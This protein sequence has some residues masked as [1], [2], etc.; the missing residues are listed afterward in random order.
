[1][2]A[3]LRA[4]F[5]FLTIL[6][7]PYPEDRQP[8]ASFAYFPLVGLLIGGL[9]WG[10]AGLA[11][12]SPELR[13]FALLL[14]WVVI[15]GALHLDGFGDSCD[16]LLAT[17]TPERRLE[18]LKDPRAGSWAIV[19]LILLLLGK[20]VSLREV[21]APL[22]L[23]PPILARWAMVAAAYWYPHRRSTGLGNYFRQGLGPRQWWVALILALLGLGLVGWLVDGRVWLLA[24]VPLFWVTLFA[25]WAMGRLGGGL[26]GDVYGAIC[27]L[28]ELSCLFVLALL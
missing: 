9:L 26:T 2:L 13:A 11:W 27:E 23:A 4:A 19:G 24:F 5:A 16:G 6:P 28:T 12:P 20:W 1:M 22:L 10:L 17:T 18:I 8:G 21:A 7:L 14:L 15:T 25:R 3:D